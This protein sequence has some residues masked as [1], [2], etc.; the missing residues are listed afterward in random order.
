M[1]IQRLCPS[2][3]LPV[4]IGAGLTLTA[5]LSMSISAGGKG[6]VKTGLSMSIAEDTYARL[7]PLAQDRMLLALS[8]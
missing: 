1:Q 7:A 8:S 3:K 6:V 5:S 4:R 2:A